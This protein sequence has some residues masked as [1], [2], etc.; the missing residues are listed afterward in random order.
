MV[1]FGQSFATGDGCVESAFVSVRD[2]ISTTDRVENHWTSNVA[3]AFSRI[4][5]FDIAVTALILA[6]EDTLVGL[7]L[8]VIF[9]KKKKRTRL[10]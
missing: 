8:F 9:V 4:S 2:T 6:L 1:N 3:L 5:D 10:S 7:K